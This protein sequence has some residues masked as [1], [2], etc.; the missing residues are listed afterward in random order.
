MN[1]FE[2]IT[3][4]YI[5]DILNEENINILIGENVNLWDYVK[6]NFPVLFALEQERIELLRKGIKSTS[7]EYREHHQLILYALNTLNLPGHLLARGDN[8]TTVM[9]PATGIRFFDTKDGVPELETRRVSDEELGGYYIH[10]YASKV[11]NFFA[12]SIA[13][14]ESANLT[15]DEMRHERKMSIM[16]RKKRV[17]R[18]KK[19]K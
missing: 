1:Y 6:D 2:P 3:R 17:M 15:P 14:K 7:K 5:I 4:Y 11:H 8:S 9:E 16:R 10:E 12:P 19:G 18:L 13:T